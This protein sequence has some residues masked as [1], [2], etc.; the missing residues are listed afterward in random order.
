MLT[1]AISFTFYDIYGIT[2]LDPNI[3]NNK[4][5]EYDLWDSPSIELT[6]FSIYRFNLVLADVI[7][8]DLFRFYP[9]TQ[10]DM[11]VLVLENAFSNNGWWTPFI[12]VPRQ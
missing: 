4:K 5:K 9:D 1:L 7:K 12:S 2:I 8:M 3:N 6:L 11:R 10:R